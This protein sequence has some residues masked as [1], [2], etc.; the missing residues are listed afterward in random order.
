MDHTC[1][2]RSSILNSYE[3]KT[4]FE[5]FFLCLKH[6]FLKRSVPLNVAKAAINELMLA[7]CYSY[8]VLHFNHSILLALVDVLVQVN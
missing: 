5:L 7:K 2:L 3:R 1:I 8:S 6:A 4:C